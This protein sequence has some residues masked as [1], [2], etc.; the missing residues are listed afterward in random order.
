[1][2]F[3]KAR[4]AV[5]SATRFNGDKPLMP[6]SSITHIHLLS[7]TRIL[8]FLFQEATMYVF[9]AFLVTVEGHLSFT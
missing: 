5:F 1:M 4:L 3:E 2:T 8:V 7:K 6:N 9:L